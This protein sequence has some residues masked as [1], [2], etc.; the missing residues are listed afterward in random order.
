MSISNLFERIASRQHQRRQQTIANFRELVTAVAMGQEPQPEAVEHTLADAGKSLDELK[1][2][3][4]RYKKRFALK[5]IVNGL[6]KLEQEHAQVQHRIAQA[7]QDLDD[8]ERK[9]GEITGPLHSRLHEI[10]L[11]RGDA[12]RAQN[13]LFDTCDDPDLRAQLGQVNS[14]LQALND[15][16][17]HLTAH[18]AQ[19]DNRSD[20]ESNRANRELSEADC[21]HRREQAAL[22]KKQADALRRQIKA[23]EK[24]Q[25]ELN[26]RRE[27]IEQRMR[28]W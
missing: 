4:D 9:H 5:A 19:L 28:E 12:M 24:A 1:C 7:D 22:F 25:T 6:P 23:N 14:E 20:T 10:N 26:K 11:A 21:D 2:E 17:Q 13:E 3:V 15:R 16:N 27:Q 8:A 18:A